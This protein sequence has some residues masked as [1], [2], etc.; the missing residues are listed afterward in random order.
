MKIVWLL[1][2]VRKKLD[3]AIMNDDDKKQ[4]VEEIIKMLV[5][6]RDR[7]NIKLADLF[8][9]ADLTREKLTGEFSRSADDLDGLEFD[10][11]SLK[12]FVDRRLAFNDL[13]NGEG[14]HRTVSNVLMGEGDH[15][16][17]NG[18][19]IHRS[20]FIGEA[21]LVDDCGRVILRAPCNGHWKYYSAVFD[22]MEICH[23]K[24]RD[25]AGSLDRDPLSNF[26]GVIDSGIEP[27]K[28]LW[29]R[30]LDKIDRLKTFFR[31]G[32]LSVKGESKRD[33]LSD[34]GNYCFLMTALF[35]DEENIDDRA[36][37]RGY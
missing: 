22:A 15:R 8:R 25:Y 32:H 4:C 30:C 3:S 24:S 21:R 35:A 37:T 17:A 9:E 10:W 26:K 36:E 5:L 27:S 7:Q 12:Q 29:M 23:S 19:K 16:T 13:S 2:H 14:G 11:E 6:L 20:R 31:E 33:A 1:T 18:T 28:G 34:L